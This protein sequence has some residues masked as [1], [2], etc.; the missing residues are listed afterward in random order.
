[1]LP[2]FSYGY[3]RSKTKTAQHQHKNYPSGVRFFLDLFGNKDS[4]MNT[5]HLLTLYLGKDITSLKYHIA[6][7]LYI[8]DRE[9]LVHN[10]FFFYVILSLWLSASLIFSTPFFSPHFLLYS[11]TVEF[12]SSQYY[13][14]HPV[15]ITL[16]SFMS[17]EYFTWRPK[18]FY[19]HLPV[20]KMMT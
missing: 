7:N 6:E 18:W 5:V 4:F 14:S 15:N 3:H 19:E 8:D 12:F 2:A 1:M 20:T 16:P 13:I 9:S 11:E 10:F 17:S